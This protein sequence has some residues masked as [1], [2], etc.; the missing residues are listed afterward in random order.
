MSRSLQEVLYCSPFATK[1]ILPNPSVNFYLSSSSPTAARRARADSIRRSAPVEL[2]EEREVEELGDGGG[3]KEE[4]LAEESLVG[5][6]DGEGGREGEGGV[7]LYAPVLEK[8]KG[9]RA[10]AAAAAAAFEMGESLS[11]ELAQEESIHDE[12]SDDE[13]VAQQRG[14]GV[15]VGGDTQDTGAG[16]PPSWILAAMAPVEREMV[17]GVRVEGGGVEGVMEEVVE[18]VAKQRR[19]TNSQK[20]AVRSALER[21]VSVI[22]GP[23]GTGMYLPPP[24]T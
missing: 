19:M 13:G 1:A 9:L 5:V 12:S 2:S 8:R 11:H 10:A 18:K 6:E 4:A 24:V 21:T 7:M 17:N 22:Q 15:R 3:E 14:R 20:R 23:P 16:T